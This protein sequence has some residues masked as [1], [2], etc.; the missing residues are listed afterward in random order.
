MKRFAAPVMIAT[1][2]SGCGETIPVLSPHSVEAGAIAQL[3]WI[4]F[5]G[6]AAILLLVILAVWLAM[7]GSEGVRQHLA[8]PRMVITGGVIFP[9]VVLSA[10]LL[11]NLSLMRSAARVPSD[12]A[13][14]AAIAVT[15]EQW[16]WRVAYA[17]PGGATIETAN[18]IRIPVGRDIVFKLRSAD[19]IHAFWVPSLGGKVD[20]IPGRETRLR[21]HATKPGV[22]RGPCTEYCGG[23]HALMTL[24]VAAMPAGEF[25]AWLARERS[26][27]VAAQTGMARDGERLFHA[28]GCGT[29]HTVRG[30]QAK[31]RIG[32]DLTHLAARRSLGAGTL[33]LDRANLARFI[34]E[35]QTVK[36]GNH[37]PEFRIFTPAQRD[38]L[39]T[40]LLGLK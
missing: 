12:W 26:D 27:A 19:V 40:Y 9:S 1:L 5:A 18:D 8:N 16:W 35:G 11:F 10:L 2:S 21:V 33:P 22:F 38:A 31:G 6:G 15:G 37:M 3:S 13:D 34:A 29:C 14:T 4:L 7:A 25:A 39:V 32:P 20:M 30:T 23:P 17:G 36:P 28:S 24:N